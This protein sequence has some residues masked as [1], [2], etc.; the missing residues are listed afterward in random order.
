MLGYVVDFISVHYETAYFPTFNVADMAI[1]I[2]A[3][4]MILDMILNP[5]QQKNSTGAGDNTA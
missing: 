3:A 2:G 4:L 5:E 1:S